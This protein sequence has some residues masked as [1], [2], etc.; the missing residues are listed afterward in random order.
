MR[1][2]W[3]EL[4]K[5]TAARIALG[6]A[7]GSLPTTPLLDFR[8]AHARARDA[9]LA[10]FDP[11]TLAGALRSLHTEVV[12]VKSRAAD[13]TEYLLRPD[14]GRMMDGDSRKDLEAVRNPNGSDLV[15]I[16]SDGLSSHA[17]NRQAP[18]LLEK[19]LP[20]FDETW[21][22][23]PLVVVR[24]GRVT[25]QD[26]IG[27]CLD[28]RLSLMLLGERPGL[29]SPDSLGAYFTYRPRP[30]LTDADRNC[31]S[32][33]RPEGLPPEAAARR[34]HLLLSASRHR[35]ISGIALKDEQGSAPG[36][37]PMEGI[38]HIQ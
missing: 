38:D 33:I 23:G 21:R 5:F 37:L 27:G 6:R 4:R 16:V 3:T 10:P 14:L 22:I 9:V 1:D 8:L 25:I 35:A 34:L 28:S 20:M 13:R 26:D 29:G 7:G 12:V 19:L 11:E 36:P 2:P 31:V 30:G 18:L 24:H 32:N 17:A 15:I